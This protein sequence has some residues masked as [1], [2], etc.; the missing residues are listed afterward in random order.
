VGLVVILTLAVAAGLAA[1]TRGDL[2]ED[3][4]VSILMV[5][6]EPFSA[7]LSTFSI[8]GTHCTRLYG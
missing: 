4:K 5:D 7:D 6:H 3:M 2:S 8:R 1:S